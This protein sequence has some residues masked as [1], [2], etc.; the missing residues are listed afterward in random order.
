MS[1]GAHQGELDPDLL[2]WIQNLMGHI[3][4]FDPWAVVALTGLA[5]VAIPASLTVLYLAQRRG[6]NY[7][8]MGDES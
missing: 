7:D 6:G 8:L 1:I 4:G 3:L 5:I 2:D